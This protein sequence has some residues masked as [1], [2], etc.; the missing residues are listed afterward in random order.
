MPENNSNKRIL[1]YDQK[2]Y[3]FLHLTYVPT[4]ARGLVFL[5][6]IHRPE[7]DAYWVKDAR[8]EKVMLKDGW[9][10]AQARYNRIK[11]LTGDKLKDIVDNRNVFYSE[12]E[13]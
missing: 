13:W 10:I 12:V 7:N 1:L 8:G 2:L 5:Y 11:E 3:F 6:W 4:N 9:D